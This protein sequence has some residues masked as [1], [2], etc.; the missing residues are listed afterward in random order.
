M[1]DKVLDVSCIGIP[2]FG[3]TGPAFTPFNLRSASRSFHDL[4]VFKDF[5][6]GGDRRLQFRVGAFNIFN[7]A[8]P[9]FRP[10]SDI[11]LTLDTVCNVRRNGVPNGLG[12][13]ADNVCDPNGG[14]RLTDNT[15]ANFGK[16]ITKR[17]HRIMEFALRLFF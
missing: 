13:T 6:L 14:Y 11:D 5:K 17:G 4:T 10:N 3:Q 8:Y 12:G 1:G 7:Q 9:G 16:I 15:I 2:G